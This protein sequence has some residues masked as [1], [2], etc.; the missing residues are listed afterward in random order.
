EHGT[1]AYERYDW[2]SLLA[3]EPGNRSLMPDLM[4]GSSYFPARAEMEENLRLFA[5]RTGLRVRYACRWTGPRREDDA[6][7]RP[8]FVVET[9]DG[10]FVAET[11]I[12]AVG[13]AE[14]HVPR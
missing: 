2:N 6:D 3:D 13:G 9:S 4:D 11:L 7:G 5:E 1:R 10:D 14:P 8:T 12:I